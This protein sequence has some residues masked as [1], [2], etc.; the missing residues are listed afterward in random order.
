MRRWC[1][2]SKALGHEEMVAIIYPPTHAHTHTHTPCPARR[3]IEMRTC[4]RIQEKRRSS[5]G[6]NGGLRGPRSERSGGKDLRTVNLG[7]GPKRMSPFLGSTRTVPACAQR[8]NQTTQADAVTFLAGRQTHEHP[9]A[10]VPP[11]IPPTDRAPV[12][13]S[14]I[15]AT[16]GGS[17]IPA[18]DT[19]RSE[20]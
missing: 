6:C 18:C 16:V 15:R 14:G 19:R 2:S 11:P 4:A 17:G 12:G 3:R 1:R 13:G 9:K 7:P 5:V 10:D 20:L 8:G